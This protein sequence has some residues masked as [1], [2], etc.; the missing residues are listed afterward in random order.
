MEKN[1]LRI[2]AKVPKR[3]KTLLLKCAAKLKINESQY[4]KLA[5]AERLEK[6]LNEKL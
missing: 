6:D 1:E 5:I 3:M 4:V 2:N